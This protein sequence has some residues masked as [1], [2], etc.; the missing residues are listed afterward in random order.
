MI[1]G[2]LSLKRQRQPWEEGLV[3]A[4]ED[5]DGAADPAT[6]AGLPCSAPGS[7]NGCLST[8]R[9]TSTPRILSVSCC[10]TLEVISCIHEFC[11]GPLTS[12]ATLHILSR[13]TGFMSEG[14]ATLSDSRRTGDRL[15]KLYFGDVSNRDLYLSSF[16]ARASTQDDVIAGLACDIDQRASSSLDS[17]ASG[18]LLSIISC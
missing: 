16:F 9:D 4:D 11:L 5:A 17:C 12:P 3:L 10:S 2:K 14:A 6:A 18:S 8:S 15:H 13:C 7:A 1:P